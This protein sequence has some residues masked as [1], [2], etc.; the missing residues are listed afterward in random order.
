[1][2][3]PTKGVV[4]DWNA[5]IGRE[6][7]GLDGIVAILLALAGLAERA[8]CAPYP[9]RCVVFWFLRR[10]D[11]VATEFVASSPCSEARGKW[12]TARMTVRDGSQLVDESSL[13][14]SL[15]SLARAVAAVVAQLRRLAFLHRGQRSGGKSLGAGHGI[16]GAFAITVLQVARPDT[17]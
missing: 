11:S 9:V 14:L 1:M 2:I 13:A 17:S 8:A 6:L 4:M 5:Q 10:A 12:L 3:T 15:G 16:A 7:R